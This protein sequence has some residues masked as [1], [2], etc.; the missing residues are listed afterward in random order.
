M[1]FLGQVTHFAE[2]MVDQI[3]E[4]A[5][6]DWDC[7]ENAKNACVDTNQL[8]KDTCGS[9]VN[10]V[11]KSNEMLLFS[12][13]IKATIEGFADG[14][15][16]S[17]L[18]KLNELVTGDKMKAAMSLAGEMDDM[19]LDCV[20]KAIEMT[21]KMQNAF[22]SLP[23]IVRD[24]IEDVGNAGDANAEKADLEP[25]IA[26]LT[27]C[28]RAITE[29]NLFT[30]MEAGMQAFN[31]LASKA[32]V[33]KAMFERIKGFAEAVATMTDSIM[34]LDVKAVID[35]VQDMCKCICM[36]D[37]MRQISE[38]VGKLIKFII[39]LFKETSEK[40]SSLWAA[41][42]FCKDC[43]SDCLVG[44]LDAKQFCVDAFEHGCSIIETCGSIEG[45]LEGISSMEMSAVASI[46]SLASGEE[47]RR[48]IDLSQSM[49]DKMLQCADRVMAMV[50][51]VKTGWD[52][53][54]PIITDGIQD[55]TEHGKAIDDPEP[56]NTERDI[57]ELDICKDEIVNANLFGAVQS[58]LKAFSGVNDKVEVCKSL[59]QTSQGAA[60]N[61]SSTIES[62]MGSWSL[63]T[64]ADK[65]K[66]ICRC[67]ALGQMIRQLAEQIKNLVK[68]IISLLQAAMDK[69]SGMKLDLGDAVS[70]VIPDSVEAGLA[71][72]AGK[73]GW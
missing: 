20:G 52:A 61:T 29:L 58:G 14:M 72:L 2:G 24:K 17:D 43:L 18:K 48:A 51:R 5:D 64:M 45:Q 34:N 57:V 60:D 50:D 23:S 26:E 54:P 39:N 70:A 46:K 44:A 65:I 42:D 28:I 59:L 40:L 31:G 41:L 38:E 12:M 66:D 15:D 32:D 62:F 37:V 56:A 3:A 8:A 33:C 63:E 47:M 67:V 9:C 16:A 49:H 25:D 55:A 21:T 11:A 6:I 53:L 73:F 68:S 35:K 27:E 4:L 71:N 1:S 19:A 10:T 13:D 22:G 30:A 69:F 36:C 7:I